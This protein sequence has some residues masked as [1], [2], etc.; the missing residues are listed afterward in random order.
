MDGGSRTRALTAGG[1]VWFCAVAVSLDFTL[2]ISLASPSIHHRLVC[3][4][5]T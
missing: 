5:L 4:L 3:Y 1:V 2:F